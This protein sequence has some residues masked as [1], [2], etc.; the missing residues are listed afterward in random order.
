[1]KTTLSVI[2]LLTSLLHGRVLQTIP[3][4]LKERLGAPKRKVIYFSKTD[5]KKI[6]LQ[7]KAHNI[8]GTPGRMLVVY[9][10]GK[11][12]SLVAVLDTHIVRTKRQTLLLFFSL[13][14]NIEDIELIRFDEPHE[15]KAPEAWLKLFQ[16]FPK[17]QLRVDAISGATLTS[18]AIKQAVI[19]NKIL[20]EAAGFF[21]SP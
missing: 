14:G 6:Q 10:N 18:R 8:P 13:D 4:A 11:K 20:L 19:R 9:T 7:W 21:S 2:L 15:Y 1:M 3:V 17:K 16:G 5:Q 12:K